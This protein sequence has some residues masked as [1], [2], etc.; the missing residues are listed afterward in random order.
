MDNHIRRA[1]KAAGITQEQLAKSLGINRATLSRYETGEIEPPI[2]QLLNIASILR[3]SLQELL[4]LEYGEGTLFSVKLSPEMIEA[5][6]FPSGVDTLTTSNPE[7]MLKIVTEFT[8]QSAEKVRLNI[9]FDS[10][11][12][13]GQKKALERVVELTEI[14]RYQATAT[15][16]ST[17]PAREDEDIATHPDAPEIP[18]EGK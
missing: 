12:S 17:P 3:T 1:R 14:P 6:N 11:N 13:D 8:R 4:G 2:S 10:L 7:L 16:E 5:L 9:A 15:T 18:P